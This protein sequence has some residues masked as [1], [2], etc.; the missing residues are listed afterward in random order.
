VPQRTM[1]DLV[2]QAKAT[3]FDLPTLDEGKIAAAGIRKLTGKY[4][5]LYTDVP[6]EKEVDELPQVFEAAVP[7]WCAYFGIEPASVADWK[8]VGS[9]MRDKEPFLGAD[10]Y[11]ERLP[12]FPNG[13]N[14]GSQLWLYDQ[15]SGY[16]R[17]HL[18][19]HEGTHAFMDRW[20]GGCGPPWYMEGIAE[21]LGTHRWQAGQLTLGI[22][23]A[24]RDE[25][26]YW[27][28]VKIVKE[29]YAA[30][31]GMGLIDIMRY[32]AHAH[33][34]N[35]PYGWCWAAAA[36]LDQHPRTQAAFRELKGET[37]DH[38]IEFSKRFYERL[39]DHWEQIS[40]D[41]QLF[42]IDCDYGY[43]VPRAAIVRKPAEDLPPAGATIMLAT[44]RGWQSCGY[45]L[46]AGKTYRVTAVGRYT[47]A[48]QPKPWPCEANGITIRYAGGHPLG[49]LLAGLSEL[50]GESPTK[51]PLADPQPIGAGGDLMPDAT[52]ALYLK[53][54]E[55]ASGLLDN[56][57]ELHV[58]IRPQ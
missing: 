57:G 21:L 4:L 19:L 1:E 46:Q 35:E 43:D 40:E 48:N 7:L 58:T 36:F 49:M 29:E 8:I 28:R 24:S 2:R 27:G 23:P 53:I 37:R 11:S 50:E 38:T 30:G 14:A 31:R 39:K 18:L 47:I 52:G 51:T 17:R 10:L 12:P 42:V 22:M 9:V 34:K 15:P 41:W 32:D 54:N 25:V 56:S 45:R 16:Y 13:Y 20:L 33:L 6:A 44:D 5:V 55:P 3:Q 26:P